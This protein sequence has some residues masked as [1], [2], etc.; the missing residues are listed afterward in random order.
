MEELTL[1]EQIDKLVISKSLAVDNLDAV[2]KSLSELI[3]QEK[4]LSLPKISS[5]D[6]DKLLS[7][8][9]E[10]ITNTR[11]DTG[12]NADIYYSIN[13]NEIEADITLTSYFT[14]EVISD[15]RTA[16]DESDFLAIIEDGN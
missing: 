11:I 6:F 15:I 12:S 14:G 1:K 5:D 16:I 10:C 3:K 4:Q 8:V 13:D 9:E 7:I 2:S